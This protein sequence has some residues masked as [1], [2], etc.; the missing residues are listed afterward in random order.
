MDTKVFKVSPPVEVYGG[1]P[2]VEV[3]GF[4]DTAKFTTLTFETQVDV[5]PIRHSSKYL[6]HFEN[7][8]W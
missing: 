7:G 4:L 1:I 8:R 2:P 3:S 6:C 5:I